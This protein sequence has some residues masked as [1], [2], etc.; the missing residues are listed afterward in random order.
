VVG[1]LR[2]RRKLAVV[3]VVAAGELLMASLFDLLLALVIA[4]ETVFF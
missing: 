4:L 1:K 3:V 2:E